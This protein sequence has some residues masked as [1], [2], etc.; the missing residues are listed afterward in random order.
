MTKK[1]KILGKYIKDMSSETPDIETY[2]FVRD[3][4][5]KYQLNID[6]NSKALKDKMV[7]VNTIL[8]FEDKQENKKK[9]YFEINYSTIVKIEENITEKKD[10]EKIVLCD[11]QIEIYPELEK[12]FLNLLHNSGYP[13]VKFEKKIDFEQLYNQ[14]LN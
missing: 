14:R 4:I 7:E 13:S 3:Y 10:L 5:S 8:K 11:V 9:S 6:I 2:I 1:Y 12:S